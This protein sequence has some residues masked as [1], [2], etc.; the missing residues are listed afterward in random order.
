MIAPNTLHGLQIA[1]CII[2]GKLSRIANEVE[3][4]GDGMDSHGVDSTQACCCG[5][6]PE[7]THLPIAFSSDLTAAEMTNNNSG[8]LGCCFGLPYHPPAWPVIPCMLG[9]V[10]IVRV[11][12]H[13]DSHGDEAIQGNVGIG[14]N[15]LA[16]TDFIKPLQVG[17]ANFVLA[18]L[19]GGLLC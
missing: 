3:L 9:A 15:F 19:P 12:I 16:R 7:T 10:N 13:N 4:L 14:V 2:T 8:L 17:I 5:T 1:G 18:N 11:W 6:L